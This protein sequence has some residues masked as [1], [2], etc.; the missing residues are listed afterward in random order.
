MKRLVIVSSAR[1]LRMLESV[2]CFG[3]SVGLVTAVP[4]AHDDKENADGIELQ[5]RDID[6]MRKK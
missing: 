3:G 1:E 2:L 6:C 4:V 5:S